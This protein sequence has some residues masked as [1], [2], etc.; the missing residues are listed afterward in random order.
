MTVRVQ[1]CQAGGQGQVLA[2]T[3]PRA[4]KKAAKV[5]L[6]RKTKHFAHLGMINLRVV[7]LGLTYLKKIFKLNSQICIYYKTHSVPATMLSVSADVQYLHY[8]GFPCASTPKK[9]VPLME[10]KFLI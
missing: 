7:A 2:S 10:V 1:R 8:H 9:R 5:Q 6:S 3:M 4:Q